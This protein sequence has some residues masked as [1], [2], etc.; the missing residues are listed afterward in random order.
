MVGTRTDGGLPLTLDLQLANQSGQGRV[1]L[2]Q[3]S[4]EAIRVGDALYLKGNK[5]F[6]TQLGAA[7]VEVPNDTWVKASAS[8]PQLAALASFT[9]PQRQMER[10]F[11][12]GPI[13]K[14]TTTTVMGQKAFTLRQATKSSP[15]IL[16]VAATGKPYPLQL[17]KHGKDS[18]EITFSGWNQPVSVTAPSKTIELSQLE[19]TSG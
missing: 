2:E 4:F 16:Y 10:L 13:V 18:A 19:K 14:G 12:L 7:G 11:T 3:L 15:G 8:D 5:A 17:V 6:Y 9:E 1:S